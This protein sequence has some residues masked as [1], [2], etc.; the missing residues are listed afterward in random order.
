[1]TLYIGVDFHARSQTVAWCGAITGEIQ[2]RTLHHLNDEV[3]SFYAQILR[4]SHRR[5]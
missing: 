4:P 1:M 5:D 3:R 2:T